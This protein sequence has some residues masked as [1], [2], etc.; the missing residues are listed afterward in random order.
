MSSIDQCPSTH[1][2][3]PHAPDHPAGKQYWRS[4][5]EFSNSDSFRPFLEREFPSGASELHEASRRTFVKLMGASFALAGAATI[6]GCRRP[7][8]KIMPYSRDVPEH[9][10]PGRPLY[11]ATAMPMLGGGAEGLLVETHTGRPTHIQG[12]PLHPVNQG[13]SSIFSIASTLDLYDPDRLKYPIYKNPARGPLMAT[14]DDFKAFWGRHLKTIDGSGASLAF[15]VDKKTS[16]SRDAVRDRVL[17]R[18]PGATWVAWNAIETRGE[19]EGGKIAFGSPVRSHH[20]LSKA[21]IV[22]SLDSNF[23]SD[24]PEAIKNARLLARKRRV[25][26]VHTDM[27]RLYVA[28]SSPTAT[29]SLADHRFRMAPSQIAAMTV[30]IAQYIM[31]KQG[32]S[33][34]GALKAALVPFANTTVDGISPEHLKAV[35]DDLFNHRGQAVVM[36]GPSQSAQVHALVWAINAAIGAMGSLVWTSPM[37][38]ELASDAGAELAALVGKIDRG[39]IKTLVCIDTNPVF[40]APAGMDFAQKY[41]KV[42]TTICQSVGSTETAAA[43]TWSLNGAHFLESWSDV[44]S[45]DGTRS[46]IQPMIAPLYE[47]AM[48]DLELLSFLRGDDEPDGYEIVSGVWAGRIGLERDSAAFDKTWRRVLHDGLLSGSAAKPATGS[49]RFDSIAEAAGP[50]KLNDAPTESSLE[51]VF[52]AGNVL[53]GRHANNGWLQEL[54]DVASKVTWTNPAYVSPATARVLGVLP[55]GGEDPYTKQQLPQ[56]RIAELMVDGHRMEL[57]VW[58]QPGMADNT[59]RVILGYGRTVCGHVGTGIGHNTNAIHNAGVAT[60]RGATLKRTSGTETIASTQDH[61]SMESR[62]AIVREIDK[63]YWDEHASHD[64]KHEEDLVYGTAA[65]VSTLNVAEQMGELAHTPPNI[66]IYQNPL[67]QSDEEPGTGSA[68]SKGPQWGM[69][70]DL[71]SCSGCGVCTIACQSENNIPIVGRNE[72]AKG[73][74]MQWI[75]V[76]RYFTG[77]DLNN[78]DGMF[79][80]PVACVHCENAPC[81]TVCPVT[82]TTHGPEG[83][84]NMVYNRCIG[85]R[86]C[87]NNCPYKVRRFNFFDWGQNK[88]NG[89][90]DPKYVGKTEAE[91]S[92]ERM[93]F[94]ENFIP[95]R[96]R[97]KVDEI[98]KMQRNPNVTVRPRGVMEKC[99]YCV[100]RINRAKQ[101]VKKRKIWTDPNSTS[102]IPD[103]FFQTACQAACPTESIVFGDILDPASAVSKARESQRRYALLGYLDTRPR[104]TYAMRVANPNE[105]IRASVDPLDHGGGHGGE[106]Q[107]NG[108]AG[109]AGAHAAYVDPAKRVADSGYALSL[110]VLSQVGAM[111]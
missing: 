52:T 21:R 94:N 69:S 59:V 4:V 44:E 67:N 41:A 66:S 78:P 49:L 29:G 99:S 79:M 43:S 22:L 45:W 91:G 40:D 37:S 74:E 13:A 5:E 46:V 1:G 55:E 88:H 7:D 32:P 14:W 85:T 75:R 64:P 89:G 19:I 34:S 61:W 57:P 81:E 72:V 110:R 39:E 71:G 36:V 6:P 68:Y 63:K 65:G 100:Q 60:S 82:A 105:K 93:T 10:I 12:N 3:E 11:Y 108:H 16:P 42:D 58:I 109:D 54:P 31:A 51:V 87:A 96:L 102:P 77:D 56:G 95:P 28:E 111:A 30:W 97:A 80:Q 15:I 73:R 24:G 48:S 18:F 8:R 23:V 103:G 83:T 101:E 47:P 70:I 90:L 107:N 25:D 104:T 50:L 62:T 2:Q 92:A 38:A 53:D 98:S 76:D 106:N 27:S 17:A 86:Y 84:N 26:D 9:I 33:G 20:D 35:A